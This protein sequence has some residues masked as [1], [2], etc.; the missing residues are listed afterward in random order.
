MQDMEQAEFLLQGRKVGADF[1]LIQVK[2]WLDFD[3][4]RNLDNVLVYASFELRC[5]IERLAFEILYLA[6]DGLLTPEEEE[7]CRS[8]KGTLEL[9]DDVESNYRKRAHFTNLVFSLYS[10]APKIAIID[11]EF[12]KRRWHELSDYLHLHARSLGAWDSPKREFQIEGFKLL[13]ETYEQIIKW[14]T[15]GKLGLLDKKSM[16]SDVE[17]IYDKFLSGEIDESQAVTRLRLAQPVLESRM[18]RKG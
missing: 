16:D 9:L 15:D 14:L 3:A 7:R 17:D 10:G 2:R 5:A 6:K 12:I 4:G 1:H 8:I 13:K 18:R 11:I